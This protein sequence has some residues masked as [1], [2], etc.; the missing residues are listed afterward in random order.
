MSQSHQTV[1][2]DWIFCPA[3][4]TPSIDTIDP[5]AEQISLS[6][7]CYP[8]ICGQIPLLFSPSTF[9]LSSFPF[10]L[11]LWLLF[12]HKVTSN[13][14]A[15]PWTTAR[16][17]SLAMGILQARILEWVAISSSRGS[18]RP[19]DGW[20]PRLLQ[21]QVNPLPLSHLVSPSPTLSRVK[22]LILIFLG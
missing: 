1:V 4:D 19:R 11:A 5:L 13:S 14:F 20:N 17:V 12:S 9:L 6:F 21:W 3:P 16:Q 2:R 8:F 18:S 15:I 7:L 10:L 22:C